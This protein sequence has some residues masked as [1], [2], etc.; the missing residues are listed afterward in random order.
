M[1]TVFATFD[2]EGELISM[3]VVPETI[4]LATVR[5]YSES[6]YAQTID[7]VTEEAVDEALDFLAQ[8]HAIDVKNGETK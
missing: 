4:D 5:H 7:E 3:F 8:V 6:S 1:A 2:D